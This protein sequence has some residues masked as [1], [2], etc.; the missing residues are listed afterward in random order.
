[1]IR[2]VGEASVNGICVALVLIIVSAASAIVSLARLSRIQS[3]DL[4]SQC[5]FLA[6][7]NGRRYQFLPLGVSHDFISLQVRD[8]PQQFTDFVAKELAG[9]Q[10]DQEMEKMG[11]AV[12][13]DLWIKFACKACFRMF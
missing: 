11:A 6:A 3:S 5:D 8:R 1:M 12:L 9:L 13:A 10:Q 4:E 7:R 2:A